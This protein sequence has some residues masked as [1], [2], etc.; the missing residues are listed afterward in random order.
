MGN[1]N[2]DADSLRTRHTEGPW[3]DQRGLVTHAV[4]SE[5]PD[6]LALLLDLGL[7]PDERDRVA[8]LEEVVL[9]LG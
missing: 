4:K 6:M 9:L 5:R 7:D 8:G 2:G 1:R 3:R